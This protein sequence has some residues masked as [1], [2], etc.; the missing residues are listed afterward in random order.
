MDRA[1]RVVIPR[2]IRRQVGL[3][4]GDVEIEAVGS[5]VRIAPIESK[6]LVRR[7]DYLFLPD[8][9]D[10]TWT[11]DDVRALRSADQR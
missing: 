7:G 9:E 2:E 6:D 11:D 10:T 5:E 8:H 1:G 3:V 4:A